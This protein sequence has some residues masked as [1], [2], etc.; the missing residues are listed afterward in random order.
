[1]LRFHKNKVCIRPAW[2]TYRA[3]TDILG[4]EKLLENKEMLLLRW[5]KLFVGIHSVPV[6]NWNRPRWDTVVQSVENISSCSAPLAPIEPPSLSHPLI[7]HRN[8]DFMTPPTVTIKWLPKALKYSIK[9][10]Y[11]NTA[12][13]TGGR[14]VNILWERAVL[15]RQTSRGSL[16]RSLIV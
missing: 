16:Q 5:Y 6:A 15:Q 7:C 9:Q 3:S 2:R 11:G 10:Q 13:G 1:M 12:K 4:L 8:C 14:G